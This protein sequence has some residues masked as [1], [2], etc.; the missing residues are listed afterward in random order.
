MKKELI[1]RK[2]LLKEISKTLSRL[3]KL[4]KGLIFGVPSL[5]GLE[6]EANPEK[7]E[8]FGVSFQKRDTK[9]RL[10]IHINNGWTT[11][12]NHDIFIKDVMGKTRI[13]KGD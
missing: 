3:F 5:T 1:I 9:K 6:L 8:I 7:G 10:S 11:V 4:T 2:F 13:L 12:G